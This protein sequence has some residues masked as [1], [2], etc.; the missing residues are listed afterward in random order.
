MSESEQPVIEVKNLIKR[1]G[2]LTV[3]DGINVTIPRGKITV[4]MGGSGIW[5]VI[6]I[7]C[8]RMWGVL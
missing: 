7:E 8:L 2:D 1:F 3:L 6:A 4:I 5:A